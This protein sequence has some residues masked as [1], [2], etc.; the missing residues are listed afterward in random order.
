[1]LEERI[2]YLE[3]K[4][5]EIEERE[6]R[7]AKIMLDITK[8]CEHLS[9]KSRDKTSPIGDKKS[10]N[11]ESRDKKS[12]KCLDWSQPW[13]RIVGPV[14][15]PAKSFWEFEKKYLCRP[16]GPTKYL[17][18][19]VALLM[20]FPENHN[21]YVKSKRCYVCK[22]HKWV[23]MK[24]SDF[25]PALREKILAQYSH[26]LLRSQ[27][28]DIEKFAE[29]CMKRASL[30]HWTNQKMEAMFSSKSFCRSP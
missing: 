15:K 11:Q 27:P 28:K 20:A 13:N 21:F 17:D 12:P 9:T 30:N 14:F 16:R 3:K 23:Q 22:D 10:P 4:V 5:C 25:Y 24:P 8:L 2:L 6:V 19:V 1:M 18:Q 26:L 29:D 7:N